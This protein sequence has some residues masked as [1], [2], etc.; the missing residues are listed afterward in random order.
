MARDGGKRP[1][2]RRVHLLA[3]GAVLAL[4]AVLR[5]R[6]LHDVPG[7]VFY[8]AAVRSMGQ[9]WHAFFYGTLEPGGRLAIDKPPLD[10]WLQVASTKALG[11]TLVGLHLPEALAGVAACGLLFGALYR[12]F[13]FTA[14]FLAAAALAVLPVSVLTAR[15]DTMD[16]LLAALLIAALWLSWRALESGEMRWSLLAAAVMGVAFN[17]KLG[18]SLIALPSMGLMWLWAAAP[19]ARVRVASATAALYVVV[20]LSW[21]AIASLTPLGQRPF[22]V[23]SSNGSIWRVTLVYNGLD[24]LSSHGATG[25]GAELPGPLRLLS[26]GSAQYWTLIGIGLLAAVLLGL[27]ALALA[28]AQGAERLGSA[29]RSPQGRFGMGIVLWFLLGLVLFSAMHRLQMRYLEAF[30][31]ALCAVLG[32]SLSSLW[33]GGG[34]RRRLLLGSI[35][36]GL[37]AVTLN[38]DVYVIHRARSDSLLSDSTSSALSHY[39]RGHRE[40]AYYEVASA[41]VNEVVGLVVRD[42]EPVL[43]LN[44]V[45][46]S[47]VRTSDLQAQ[48]AAGR[49]RFYFAPRACHSGRYCAGNQIWAYAHSVPVANVFGLRRFIAAAGQ[50]AVAGA[51]PPPLDPHNIYA[52]DRAGALSPTVRADRALVYVPNSA[53]NTV[54]VISQRSFKVVEHFAVGALPQ[55]VTPAWDLRT[56]YVTNDA[57]NSLTPIDPRSGHPGRPI[58]VHDPYNMYFTADGRWAIVVA[59]AH[60]ELDFRDA[61]SFALHRALT[62]PQ[63]AG[64]DHM[65][66]TADGR[67][68]LV[69]CEFAGRAIV[70]DLQREQVVKTIAL[71]LEA[72]PQDVKLSPDGSVFYVAD[73]RTGGV[74][75]IDAHTLNRIGFVHTGAGA[76]GL[77]PSRDARQLYVSNRGE[78]SISVLSFATRHPI[79]K[80]QLPGGGSPDMGGVSADGNVLWLSGRYDG[81]VYAISTHTGRL[82][83]RIRVGSGPHGLCV[84]PQPGR[85]SIGHTGILR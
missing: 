63:C 62:T 13:G 5:L 52:A 57:G 24:R 41:N 84:W 74:W 51:V 54:D 66:F 82:L 68:A 55:H 83:H 61:H 11:F 80:W 58:P 34:S 3:V 23:G 75:L 17:V 29:L 77:Y 81:V 79:A 21:T 33:H 50:E 48:V 22:P 25:A 2:A 12:A 26:A 30:A 32:L 37:L 9:S 60:R 39:L 43:A 28:L 46:G 42:G 36:L 19:G 45:D 15:S 85:Y 27:V 16:S 10:L 31:P 20:A 71:A 18:E 47:V 14:A 53:S 4:A 38:K 73:M 76:H 65:D 44:S 59:E 6:L 69:S 70:V 56:L 67:Y 40:G 8:D 72:M 7:N 78:G 1:R 35:A 64:V 49:V